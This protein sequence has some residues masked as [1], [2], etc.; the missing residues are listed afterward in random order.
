[1]IRV[2]DMSFAYPGSTALFE[3][4]TM[5]F[6][7]SRSYALTGPSGRGKSTLLYILGLLMRPT[8]GRVLF[9]QW[10]TTTEQ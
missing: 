7:P 9:S 2:E 3:G 6:H 8:S 5:D 10:D 1:M 4:L